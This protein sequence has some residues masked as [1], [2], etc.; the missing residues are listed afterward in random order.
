MSLLI[1][2]VKRLYKVSP[3]LPFGFII[4]IGFIISLLHVGKVTSH[5]SHKFFYVNFVMFL[6]FRNFK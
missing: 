3:G 4:S 1:N 6:I 2:Q 5:L